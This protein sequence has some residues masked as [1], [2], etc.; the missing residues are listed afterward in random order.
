MGRKYLEEIGIG[1]EDIPLGFCLE[2]ASNIEKGRGKRWFL[3][4]EKYGFDSRE[5]WDL[6][7]TLKL[8]LYERLCMYNEKLVLVGDELLKIKDIEYK[9]VVYTHKKAIDKILA[10]FELALTKDNLKFEKANDAEIYIKINDAMSLFCL[11]VKDIEYIG[12]QIGLISKNIDLNLEEEVKLYGFNQ[13]DVWFLIKNFK[14]YLYKRLKMYDEVTDNVI[15]KSAK[16][17]NIEYNDEI[18]TLQE[19]IDKILEGLELDI[20]CSDLEKSSNKEIQEKIDI[21]FNLL[22]RGI[23]HLWW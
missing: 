9:G 8:Y 13:K 4:R 16:F 10:G 23:K 6:D 1:L 2:E 19:Y 20:N 7:Y 21:V 12:V 14:E 5:T 15:D 3:E 17:H 22:P 11:A 18:L